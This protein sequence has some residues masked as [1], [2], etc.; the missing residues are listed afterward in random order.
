MM[1]RR[2]IH[3]EECAIVLKMGYSLS[4]SPRSFGVVAQLGHLLSETGFRV[5]KTEA[6]VLDYS[7]YHEEANR[8]WRDSFHALISEA[9]PFLLASGVTSADELAQVDQ[10]LSI[11]MFQRG[12]CGMGPLF[13]FYAQK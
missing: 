9:T 3:F 2:D 4:D 7:H 8:A 13:T 10:H 6:S 1:D 5:I 11:E 12:F